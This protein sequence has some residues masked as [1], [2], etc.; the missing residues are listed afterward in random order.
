MFGFRNK[1]A[2]AADEAELYLRSMF[3]D[4]TG[5]NEEHLPDRVL[6]DP[7][8]A[9]FLQVLTTHAVANVYRWRMPNAAAINE[10]LEERFESAGAWVRSNCPQDARTSQCPDAPSAR[11]VSPWPP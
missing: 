11:A 10:V 9:G 1:Q 2:K 7:Y 4:V 3:T 8:V 5:G 6:A